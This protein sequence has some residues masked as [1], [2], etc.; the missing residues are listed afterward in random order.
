MDLNVIKEK[1]ILDKPVGTEKVQV[2]VEGDLIVP[3][4]KPDVAKILQADGCVYIKNTEIVSD[5]VTVDGK[6]DLVLIYLADG[7]NARVHNMK[8][9]FNL[10]DFIHLDGAEKGMNCAVEAAIDHIDYKI[11]NGRKLNVRALVQL[12]CRLTD[13][14]QNEVVTDVKGV[15]DIQVL[16]DELTLSRKYD[17]TKEKY[18]IEDDVIVSLG[19]PNI[20]EILKTDFR[21]GNKEV[22]VSDGKVLIKGDLNVCALYTVDSEQ[23]GVDF[24][25]KDISFSQTIVLV[26]AKEDMHCD[27]DIKVSEIYGE[28][29][30][31]EDGED[32]IL[33]VEV[34][35]E[36]DVKLYVTQKIGL[37]KDC[38]APMQNIELK[39][40]NIPY[41]HIICKNKNQTVVKESLELDDSEPNML[42][43]YNVVGKV[44]I[45]DIRPIEDKVVVE[46]SIDTVVL[47]LASDDQNPLAVHEACIPF[48]QVIETKGTT[49]EMKVELKGYIE[50][51]SFNMLSP[52]EVEVRFVL[53]FDAKVV[54]DDFLSMTVDA[55]QE[56]FDT[57]V[58]ESL[59]SV[60]IYLVQPEDTLWM[61][62]KKYNVTVQELKE[63]NDLTSDTV[64]PG[65]KLMILKN[66]IIEELE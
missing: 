42:Q 11:L 9:E 40:Q 37:L 14:S 33:H 48:R 30:C 5:R 47:Y 24:L 19:K 55:R 56:E 66:V 12:S 7:A 52:S 10:N 35:L 36:T 63:L 62:A 1:I 28:I 13:T 59:P 17:E 44:N 51:I 29:K 18:I 20:K 53:T 23:Q 50:N 34:V 4:I 49:P 21:I 3:D 39:K 61:I 43:V 25:E 64:Y 58:L 38:Y 27:V 32:R 6:V 45:D 22:K 2:I 26:G 16:K 60:T 8:H 54:K 65:Q 57:T 31:D 41:K 46:G 15:K